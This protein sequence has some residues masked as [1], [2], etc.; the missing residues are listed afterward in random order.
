M[1]STKK[2]PAVFWIGI[3]VIVALLAGLTVLSP[4][5][6]TLGQAVKI[7]YLHVALTRAGWIGL[8]AAGLI[9]LGLLISGREAWDRWLAPVFWAGMGLYIAG[10]L[11]SL[12]AQAASWG[13]IAWQEPRVASALNAIAAGVIVG[14]LSMWVPWPRVRG[15]LA[16]AFAV[17]LGWVTVGAESVLHPG[18]AIS[19]SGSAAIILST[20]GLVG[21]ALA[22][23][24]WIVYWVG[25]G[26]ARGKQDSTTEADEDK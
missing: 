18:A 19:G 20:W 17:Y 2:R 12:A 24:A 5:E 13:G 8:L 11:I 3:A 14:V 25:V 26:A 9:G 6:Q 16:A 22:L 15:G 1:T 21:L 4:A 10:F 23:G 7:V